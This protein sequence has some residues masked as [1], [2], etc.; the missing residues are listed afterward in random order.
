MPDPIITFAF[1]VA[2]LMGA[3]FHV[4]VGG[5]AR[6]LAVFLMSGWLG[7]LLGHLAGVSLGVSALMIGELR[8]LTAVLGAL[9]ALFVAYVF[10]SA[11]IQRRAPR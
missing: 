9:F 3:F 7:F 10:T 5:G 1:I 11:R 2:T 8:M 4:I 6:R